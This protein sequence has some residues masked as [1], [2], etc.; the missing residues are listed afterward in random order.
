MQNNNNNHANELQ[1]ILSNY[2]S[3]QITEQVEQLFNTDIDND[4]PFNINNNRRRRDFIYSDNNRTNNRYS[5]QNRLNR[6]TYTRNNTSNRQTSNSSNNNNSQNPYSAL[7]ENLN[8]QML[9]YHENISLYLNILNEF[10]TNE[11]LLNRLRPTPIIQEI[12][13]ERPLYNNSNNPFSSRSNYGFSSAF[14][15]NPF[16]PRNNTEQR[17]N[18]GLFTNNTNNNNANHTSTNTEPRMTYSFNFLPSIM[19][20]SLFTNVIVR[21][22]SEQIEAATET[23]TYDENE[24]FMNNQCP[25]SLEDFR[26]GEQIRRIIHCGHC[27]SENSFTRWFNSNVRCPICR[28]DIR[29]NIP[30]TDISNNTTVNRSDSNL[31]ETLLEALNRLETQE[32]NNDLSQNNNVSNLTDAS[33]NLALR[34][35]IPLQYTASFDSSNNFISGNFV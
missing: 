23:L 20:N 33:F 12:N 3:E 21:P 9:E 19:G 15:T 34:L 28:H 26:N 22:S 2:L 32:I 29:D 1:N 30:G 5:R 4:N 17:N 18:T 11:N 35:E 16:L 8:Q 10:I 13:T 27:F 14:N 6:N 25:I 7:L 24:T 31:E